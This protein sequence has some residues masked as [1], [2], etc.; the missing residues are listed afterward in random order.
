V[1]HVDVPAERGGEADE[2]MKRPGG[3]TMEAS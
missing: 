1:Y 3:S 2:L